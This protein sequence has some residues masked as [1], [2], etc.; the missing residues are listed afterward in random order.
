MEIILW[1][2][3]CEKEL[4]ERILRKEACKKDLVE[5][6]LRKGK[7]GQS[8]SC[9]PQ[10]GDQWLRKTPMKINGGKSLKHKIGVEI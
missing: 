2:G 9:I 10:S 6:N 8:K 3:A 5:R 1:K 7:N 4:A